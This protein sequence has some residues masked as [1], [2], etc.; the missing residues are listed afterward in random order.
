M[1][2]FKSFPAL[3]LLLLVHC[4]LSLE[5]QQMP[6]CQKS[7]PCNRKTFPTGDSSA[8]ATVD[9]KR[10]I[11][12]E[13]TP[14][15]DSSNALGMFYEEMGFKFGRH[16][17]GFSHHFN[18]KYFV[19]TCGAATPCTYLDPTWYRFKVV[20]NP[21]ERAVSSFLHCVKWKILPEIEKPER[22]SFLD[23][24]T[25][26]KALPRDQNLANYCGYGHFRIQSTA[27]ERYLYKQGQRLFKQI[28]HVENPTPDLVA[29]NKALGTHFSLRGNDYAVAS[30][31]GHSTRHNTTINRFVGNVSYHELM[32]DP[33]AMPSYK[34]FYDAKIYKM[35][36]EIYGADVIMYGYTFPWPEL[37]FPS[38]QLEIGP[39]PSPKSK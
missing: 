33:E 1:S 4:G 3:L 25:W 17:E 18:Q 11:L 6:A 24:I 31:G 27:Y 29:I 19:K 21:Y 36:S 34:Y 23:F 37:N 20:R 10:K 30:T 13:W 35:V 39:T 7:P 5:K 14:K 15:S 32:K 2:K 8:P 12:M 9:N 16:Y 28:V 26:A 38:L 22:I